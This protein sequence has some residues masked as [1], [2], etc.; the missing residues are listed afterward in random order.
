MTLIC[1]QNRKSRITWT[2][3]N[4][5]LTKRRL[6]GKEPKPRRRNWKRIKRNSVKNEA[7]NG[8]DDTME[9]IFLRTVQ[10]ILTTEEEA[11]AAS[12]KTLEEVFPANYQDEDL[13]VR[14]LK[15]AVFN[16][17]TSREEVS[18]DVDLAEAEASHMSNIF[19]NNN[20]KEGVLQTVAASHL[21]SLAIAVPKIG[22][23]IK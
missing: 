4:E 9:H 15:V 17:E 11:E 5:W 3:R 16:L 8:A 20:N 21:I 2:R 22:T 23:A 7:T 1:H 19:I 18:K 12:T 6:L 14:A 10:L 13:L